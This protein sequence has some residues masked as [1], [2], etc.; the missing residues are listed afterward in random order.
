VRF[1]WH[2]LW[3]QLRRSRWSFQHRGVSVLVLGVGVEQVVII[4]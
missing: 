4:Q 3:H 2:Y 1:R